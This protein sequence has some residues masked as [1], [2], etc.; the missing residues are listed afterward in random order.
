[1]SKNNNDTRGK[2]DVDE[3]SDLT[4]QT[5]NLAITTKVVK[6]LVNVPMY[7]SDSD[8][9]ENSSDESDDGKF[10]EDQFNFNIED[11]LSLPYRTFNIVEKR[12]KN[13]KKKII[14]QKRVGFELTNL[15]QNE[16]E[17]TVSKAQH[18]LDL[19]EGTGGLG[20]SNPNGNLNLDGLDLNLNQKE[21]EATDSKAKIFLDL[22]EKTGFE[23]QDKDNLG[24]IGVSIGL[25]RP[26]SL[27]N[28]RNKS[29]I[30]QLIC[31]EESDIKH[32]KF[33]FFWGMNWTDK[34]GNP[35][36]FGTVQSFYKQLKKKDSDKAK[37]FLEINEDEEGPT[38]PYQDIREKI[39]NHNN[40]K[41]LLETLRKDGNAL[42]YFSMIDSDTKSFNG[43]Y[44]AYLRITGNSF[45][46][47]MSTG[48]EYSSDRTDY[49]LHV[50]SH[51]D[52]MV[53]VIT[54]RHIQL[55]VYYPE[56]NICI[57]IP[58]KCKTL[59]ESFIDQSFKNKAFESASL[60]R[61][62][63]D[64]EDVTC[65]FSEDKPLI[66]TIPDRA[67]LTKA[68]K[69][70]IK[71]SSMFKQRE[72]PTEDDIRFLKQVTQSHFHE[73]V[74]Y[75]NLF[76][77]GSIKYQR[78]NL[79]HCKTLLAKVRNGNDTEKNQSIIELKESCITTP[80]VV[81]AIAKAAIEINQYAQKIKNEAKLLEVLRNLN[82][83]ISNFSLDA[84]LL[85][86]K[87]E[88]LEMIEKKEIDPNDLKDSPLKE[89]EAIFYSEESIVMLKNRSVD[90]KDLLNLY[91]ITTQTHELD[92]S[93]VIQE[94]QTA[95]ET[96]EDPV[97]YILQ[98]YK[99]DPL[100]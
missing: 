96:E 79:K 48:Y 34:S 30:K 35:V 86:V 15:D 37:K 6:F 52:R 47:V 7:I 33:G 44:S 31:K 77:N 81:D 28:K 78:R 4:K 13:K 1:M 11:K 9:E 84:I 70:P 91:R 87:E 85:L 95:V 67:K 76:I 32:N 80:G 100:H 5:N 22:L 75:D 88:I 98:K 26:M 60:L 8:M 21:T 19:L 45:P 39:K 46:T 40:S 97:S 69:N 74:W 20:L 42:V 3:V 59:P 53:R 92:F 62:I 63:K 41:I 83:E 10:T 43:I 66:T 51:V 18:F 56:P 49:P 99:E 17:A 93:V 89:L 50:A 25:N 61:K 23:R 2:T 29:L 38:P 27:S 55:G 58:E 68:G 54:V 82:I 90:L 71:F 65:V 57:L 14:I 73:K 36:K 16:T 72:L 24:N 64:R 12:K 94:F